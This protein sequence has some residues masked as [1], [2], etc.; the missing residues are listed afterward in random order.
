MTLHKQ[1]IL[2]QLARRFTYSYMHRFSNVLYYV[3]TVYSLPFSM[4]I[5]YLCRKD[6]NTKNERN[7]ICI[8]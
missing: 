4:H 6:H 1:L 5:L 2:R 3:I 8:S 7:I